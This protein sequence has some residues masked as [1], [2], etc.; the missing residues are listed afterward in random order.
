MRREQ[1]V[2]RSELAAIETDAAHGGMLKIN[3]LALWTEASYNFV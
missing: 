1:S 3:P 2:T